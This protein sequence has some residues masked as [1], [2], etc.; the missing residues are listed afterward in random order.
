MIKNA[1]VYEIVDRLTSIW[2]YAA[3][4]MMV[5]TSLFLFI[6]FTLLISGYLPN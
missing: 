4:T 2:A 6:C 5:A 1:K 3:I